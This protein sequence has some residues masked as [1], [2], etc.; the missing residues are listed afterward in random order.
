LSQE[1]GS[2]LLGANAF[3]QKPIE[4]GELLLRGQSLIAELT[5]FGFF[6]LPFHTIR[7]SLHFVLPFGLVV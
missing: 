2:L 3:T 4:L 1:L 5:E 7:V 6:A